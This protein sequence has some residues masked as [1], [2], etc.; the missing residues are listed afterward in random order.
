MNKSL[1]LVII[2]AMDYV[3]EIVSIEELNNF[4]TFIK[5]FIQKK[6]IV[7]I[8]GE[9]GAGKTTFVKSFLKL[10]DYEGVSSPTFSIIN[11]YQLG[12]F[13]II[14]ADFYRIENVG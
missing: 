2:F 1:C 9:L 4:V 3:V 14:H 8:E 12:D 5:N 6:D 7:C 10:F 11:E 13:K